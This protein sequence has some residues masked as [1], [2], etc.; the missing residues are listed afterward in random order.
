VQSWIQA[1]DPKPYVWGAAGPG[2]FDCSGIASAVYGQLTGRGGGSGQRY[3]TTSSIGAAQGFRP[4]KGTFTIGTTSGM[5]HMAGN[6]AGLGFEARSS[7]TGIFTGAAARSVDSFAR[8][9]YL[10]QVGGQF[11]AGGGGQGFIGMLIQKAL[12]ALTGPI[13]RG[14]DR[15]G[16]QG[17]IGKLV[18]AMGKRLVEGGV[19]WLS[20][21]GGSAPGGAAVGGGN[22][23][24]AEAWIIA[25]ES[26]GNVHAD[27]PT[28][29]AFGLGQLLAGNRQRIGGILGFSPNTTDYAQQLAMFRYYVRER[30][31]T[32]EAAQAFWQSHGWYGAGGLVG[33]R[34]GIDRVPRTMLAMLHGEE[35]VLPASASR[36]VR[37]LPDRLEQILH[38]AMTVEP[39]AVEVNLD[40]RTIA[41]VVT[42][43]Q[44]R[45][46]YFRGKKAG[47]GQ[48]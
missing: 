12:N 20:G 6:L 35:S 36:V 3:F 34:N 47:A 43:R 2:A 39:Q 27:N 22:L 37:S 14:L 5:G 24:P 9:F 23:S 48:R 26:S 29:T 7:A 45:D 32:A 33:M 21:A 11:I 46:S 10:P 25:R 38:A 13:K 1:Q 4:G 31:G 16:G 42:E 18:A 19:R 44:F 8:Q 41:R 28:S 15:L 30:Y 40:G 17:I